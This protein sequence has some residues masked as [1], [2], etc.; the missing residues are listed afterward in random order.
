MASK[1][2]YPATYLTTL[3]PANAAKVAAT[4]RGISEMP[5]PKDPQAIRSINARAIT[6]PSSSRA[7]ASTRL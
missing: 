4:T 6:A 2:A 7:I 1:A 5:A 3:S